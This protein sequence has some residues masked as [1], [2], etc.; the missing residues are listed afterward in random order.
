MAGESYS[1]M[2]L[3]ICH[4]FLRSSFCKYYPTIAA[5][6]SNLIKSSLLVR[7]AYSSWYPSRAP[8]SPFRGGGKLAYFKF[9]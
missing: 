8:P 4:F 3:Y 2:F 1:I 7:M 6:M 9:T 5:A